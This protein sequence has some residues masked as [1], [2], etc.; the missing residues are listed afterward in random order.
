VDVTVKLNGNDTPY[1]SGSRQRAAGSGQKSL[2]A[3]GG[4]L[5]AAIGRHK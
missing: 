3:A 2:P 4:R 5:R 1:Y